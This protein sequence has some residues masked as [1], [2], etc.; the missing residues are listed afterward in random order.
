[1][2]LEKKDIIKK[3]KMGWINKK[4]VAKK[5]GRKKIIL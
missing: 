2:S 3:N 5:R 1:M 4:N